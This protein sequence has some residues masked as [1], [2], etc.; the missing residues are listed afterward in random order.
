MVK[1]IAAALLAGTAAAP[2]LAQD[3]TPVAAGTG[4]RIEALIGYDAPK[5]DSNGLMYGVGAGF[6]FQVGK[7]TAGIEGEY[8]ETNAANDCFEDVLQAGDKLCAGIGRD[9]YAGGRIGAVVGGH[10]L[11]YVK[12][13]YV[14]TRLRAEYDDGGNGALDTKTSESLDG[15]RAGVGVEFN[16]PTLGFGSAAFIKGEYR[17]TNY[18]QGFERHQGVAGI[19][20][21]F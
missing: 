18:E 20:F 9:L 15:V 17:Y 12:G 14:N 21:R 6:D 10:N 19:G 8:S 4:P 11:V 7:L 13:G 5:D 16:I 1:L 3:A 2:A